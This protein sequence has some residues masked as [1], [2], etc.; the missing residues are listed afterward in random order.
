M[1]K[2]EPTLASKPKADITRNPKQ[3]YQWLKVGLV[4]VSAQKIEK[5][6]LDKRTP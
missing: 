1:N 2:A 6:N 4:N 5:K 3:G